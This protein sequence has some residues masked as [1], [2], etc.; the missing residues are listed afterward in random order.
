M[1]ESTGRRL[2]VAAVRGVW[3][4][5]SGLAAILAFAFGVPFWISAAA[6]AF[7]ALPALSGMFMRGS[8]KETTSDEIEI[9]IWVGVATLGVAATGPG[10]AL[11]AAY[12]IPLL[13]AAGTR[14]RRLLM[15]TA[16]FTAL[17]L[18]LALIVGATGHSVESAYAV[19]LSTSFAGASLVLAGLV[20]WRPAE[21]PGEPRIGTEPGPDPVLMERLR[22]SE[23]RLGRASAAAVEAREEAVKAKTALEARTRFFAQTSHELR[24]PLNAV[25]GFA[26]LMKN[27][28]FGPLPERYQEY[29]EL[30]HEGGRDLSLIVDDVLDLSRMEAGKYEIVPDLISLTDLAAEAVNFMQVEAAR[31]KIT[32]VLEDGDA[33]A[34]VDAKAVR[35]I[36]LN[37]ISNALKFTPAG[38]TVSLNA[39]EATGGAWLACSDTGAG[40]SV[41]ELRRLSRAFEQ[42]A[43]GQKEK[44]TGLG[45]SVVRAFAELHGG[46]LDIES[47]EGGGSTVAVFFP[48]EKSTG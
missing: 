5:L 32:L 2:K 20:M 44:G 34:Y 29:A 42:G 12:A 28:L 48:G 16:G 30:I 23:E 22:Q 17:G 47:R 45:L 43:A 35:Q 38:G 6:F 7:A 21:A 18:I 27:A 36:A 25:I 11:I 14:R 26:E 31:K 40:M 15:E 39:F 33:E 1:P 9:A 3:L 46:K 8:V 37:L 10:S 13:A 41:E 4:G 19:P 24:T